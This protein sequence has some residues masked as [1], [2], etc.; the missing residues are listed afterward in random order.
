M[1]WRLC[2]LNAALYR[3]GTPLFYGAATRRSSVTFSCFFSLL[4]FFFFWSPLIFFQQL[5]ILI[6]GSRAS[7]SGTQLLSEYCPPPQKHQVPAA[8][9]QNTSS[10]HLTT[11]AAMI[12]I[13]CDVERRPVRCQRAALRCLPIDGNSSLPPLPPHSSGLQTPPQHL[14]SSSH[15]LLGSVLTQKKRTCRGYFQTLAGATLFALRL[16]P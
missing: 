12:L 15:P 7:Q 3:T 14:L 4:F 2:D 5:N 11:S 9:V 8:T 10:S 16:Q 6:D 1:Y 13:I